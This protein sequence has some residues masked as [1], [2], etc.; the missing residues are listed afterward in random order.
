MEKTTNYKKYIS[1]VEEYINVT[2]LVRLLNDIDNIRER[3]ICDRE[4]FADD[5]DCF[6]LLVERLRTDKKCPNCGDNLFLSDLPQ[7][8]YVCPYCDENFY[9]IEVSKE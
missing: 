8:D 6:S 9:E 2:S 1:K 3:L 7:Y 5:I 4:A